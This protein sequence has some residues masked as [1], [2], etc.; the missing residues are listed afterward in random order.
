MILFPKSQNK[1][2]IREKSVLCNLSQSSKSL[3]PSLQEI[4]WAMRLQTLRGCC[5][6]LLGRYRK[7][8]ALK[9]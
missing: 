3:K 1:S 5:L 7:V 4:H 2:N 9:I 8:A 6:G